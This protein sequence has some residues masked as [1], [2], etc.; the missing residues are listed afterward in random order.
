[1]KKHH[2][3]TAPTTA[4]SIRTSSNYMYKPSKQPSEASAIHSHTEHTQNTHRWV[5]GQLAQLT[6]KKTMTSPRPHPC[7]SPV[8]NRHCHGNHGIGKIFAKKNNI[9]RFFRELS[10]R[11]MTT[12]FFAQISLHKLS[13]ATRHISITAGLQPQQDRTKHRRGAIQLR[14]LQKH[15]VQSYLGYSRHVLLPKSITTA[16]QAN[17]YPMHATL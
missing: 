10:Q 9:S 2:L 8:P 4:P 1:M 5:G 15:R 12:F 16:A 13:L 11:E 17:E 14:L 7:L 6:R 3:Q